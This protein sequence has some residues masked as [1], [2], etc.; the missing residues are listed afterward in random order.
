MAVENPALSSAALSGTA[1]SRSS[2]VMRICAAMAI[3]YRRRGGAVG[4]GKLVAP[5]TV[6]SLAAD[7]REEACASLGEAYQLERNSAA[8]GMSASSSPWRP[9]S[10]VGWWSRFSYRSW[11]PA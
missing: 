9:R 7:L 5:P 1:V 3:S 2:I 8:G 4:G 10:G 6:E 11:R